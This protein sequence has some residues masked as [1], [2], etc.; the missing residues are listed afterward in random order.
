MAG[1]H[2]PNNDGYIS[3]LEQTVRT[4]TKEVRELKSKNVERGKKSNL[5]EMQR[6]FGWSGEDVMLSVGV[7]RFSNEYLFPRQKFI[8]ETWLGYSNERKSFCRYVMK[9]MNI[10]GA[11]DSA[12][13]WD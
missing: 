1:I 12:R 4:L 2:I 11:Y 8:D 10:T 5:K 3:R 7:M 9:Q 13:E 6:T